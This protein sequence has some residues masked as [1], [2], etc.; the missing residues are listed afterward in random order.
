M[1]F[2][3]SILVTPE[4]F[5]H[6]FCG[7]FVLFRRG[8]PGVQLLLRLVACWI[9]KIFFCE[10]SRGTK[11]I[12]FGCFWHVSSRSS[13][14]CFRTISRLS[15]ACF[16]AGVSAIFFP[17]GQREL[18]RICAEPYVSFGLQ[19]WRWGRVTGRKGSWWIDKGFETKIEIKHGNHGTT[20]NNL[21][22]TTK[23]YKN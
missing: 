21:Q 15:R 7:S 16:V 17:W 22:Q 5:P 4:L 2:I 3:W 8:L 13:R 6:S 11:F 10:G 12:V 9:R 23:K 18:D 1:L 14:L 19:G 20:W